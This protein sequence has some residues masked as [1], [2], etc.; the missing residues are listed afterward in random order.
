MGCNSSP[1]EMPSMVTT[2][3]PLACPTSTVQD[4]TALPSICTTQAPHWL[5]SQPTWVPVKFRWSR[6]SCTRRVRSSTSAETALPFTVNL[7]VDTRD[8]SPIAFCLF[9]LEARGRDFATGNF[10]GEVIVMS[11]HWS[12]L[13]PAFPGQCMARLRAD[14]NLRPFIHSALVSAPTP[15]DQPLPGSAAF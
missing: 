13:S 3:A 8:T 7:T 2:L 6:R 5:V 15:G 10:V 12:R 11:H 9:R 4:L 14:L 1:L